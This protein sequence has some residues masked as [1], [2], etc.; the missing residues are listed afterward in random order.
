MQ[1][2]KGSII[3]SL[4]QAFEAGHFIEK[5]IWICLGTLGSL[6]FGYLLVSQVT[7]WD[8]NS[9]L[10]LQQQ[11]YITEIDFPAIT[12]CTKSSTKFSIVERIGNSLDLSLDFAK[13]L[14][15]PIRNDF[16]KRGE[17]KEWKEAK[18]FYE[19]Q[20][21]KSSTLLNDAMKYKKFCNVSE[22]DFVSIAKKEDLTNSYHNFVEGTNTA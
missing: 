19:Q 22:H 15:L 17:E 20:C 11:K 1:F 8:E 10:V 21:V 4:K 9:I 7:S 2:L 16:I 3:I 5:L 6:Y 14:L 13:K 18:S 12:F